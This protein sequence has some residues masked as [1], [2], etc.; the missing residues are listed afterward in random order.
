MSGPSLSESIFG[1][2]GN[3]QAK[4]QSLS[5]LFGSSTNLPDKPNNLNFPEP[6]KDRQQRERKEEKKRKRKEK[7][8][9]G[10]ETK[11]EKSEVQATSEDV[12]GASKIDEDEEKTIFVGNLPSDITRKKLASLFK[13]C[14]KVKSARLRSVA[15]AGVKV[16]PE[17]A[18]NQVCILR[19]H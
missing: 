15:I 16:P 2:E 13:E 12:Q 4:D 19:C 14:G 1:N 10:D 3:S 7:E 5:N 18:G 6:A 17:H 11:S 8:K 9:D